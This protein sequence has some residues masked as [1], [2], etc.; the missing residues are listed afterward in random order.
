MPEQ[1]LLD[2]TTAEPVEIEGGDG[3]TVT[4]DLHGE[5]VALS[6]STEHVHLEADTATPAIELNYDTDADEVSLDVVTDEVTLTLIEDVIGLDVLPADTIALTVEG[7]IG[8]PGPR[9]PA[10]PPG[11]PG[12]GVIFRW[13]Q[14]APATV[15]TVPHDLGFYPSVS[16]TDTAGTQVYGDVLYL[17]EN[18]VQ[19]TFGLAFAGYANL[20]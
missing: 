6:L 5:T 1:I 17:D 3:E 13:N 14:A 4:L 18:T 2:L 10:G 8:P 15:W 16:T 11:P 12:A 9:G 7:Q 20:S 19:V